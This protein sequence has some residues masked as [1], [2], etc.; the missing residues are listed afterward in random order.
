MSQERLDEGNFSVEEFG[1]VLSQIVDRPRSEQ[2]P[3]SDGEI[4]MSLILGDINGRRLINM[5]LI[6]NCICLL[7][8][9]YKVGK[10]L[11]L[12]FN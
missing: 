9:E 10:V 4:L 3:K 7:N 2:T 5:E 6:Q 11:I 12:N 1:V 8:D